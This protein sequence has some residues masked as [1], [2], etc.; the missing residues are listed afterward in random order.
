MR[1]FH[2]KTGEAIHIS[3]IS[4]QWAG[5]WWEWEELCDNSHSPLPSPSSL[6]PSFP[7]TVFILLP[8]LPSLPP[9]HATGKKGCS[10]LNGQAAAG[11]SRKRKRRESGKETSPS[12]P[13][14]SHSPPSLSPTSPLSPTH[15]GDSENSGCQ[16][17]DVGCHG[18]KQKQ[19]RVDHSNYSITME[20]EPV[21]MGSEVNSRTK[22]VITIAIP[23]S[24]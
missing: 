18:N 1:W 9:S 17:D 20:V 4:C 3:P 24:R 14:S 12:L 7:L 19:C 2:V 21:L 5:L 15:S 11:Q 23:N 13:P 6:A 8:S 22:V 10:Q 16:G